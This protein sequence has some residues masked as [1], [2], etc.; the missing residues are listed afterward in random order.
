MGKKALLVLSVLISGLVPAGPARALGTVQATVDGNTVRAD[1]SLPGG[2]GVEVSLS[3]EQVVGLSPAALGLSAEL[4]SPA[5]SRIASRLPS[6]G[7]VTVPSAFPVLLTITPPPAGPLSFTGVAALELHTHNLQLTGGCPLR[8]FA[9]EAGG[10]FADIT[11]FIGAGS[12]RAGGTRPGF[13]EFLIVSDLR[14]L[15]AVI[16]G[17]FSRL[18]A[19]LEDGEADIDPAVYELLDDQLAAAEGAY[20]QAA[21]LTA[22]HDLE[23]FMATVQAH[24]GG[25]IPNVWRAP[26]DLVNV[27]GELRAAAGTLKFSLSLLG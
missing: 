3:F 20:G 5:D 25:E 27:A 11:T 15:S 16:A 4:V 9:A 23:D 21:V 26:R 7:L 1:V 18:R 22:I 19:V 6:G 12:Y 24:G 13:S 10:P 8:L 2:V 14:P 17:K